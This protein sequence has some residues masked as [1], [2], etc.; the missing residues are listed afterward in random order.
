MPFRVGDCAGDVLIRFTTDLAINYQGGVEA[1][2][3]RRYTGGT[4]NRRPQVRQ[5]QLTGA[6]PRLRLRPVNLSRQGAS[7]D[8]GVRVIALLTAA[9]FINYIDRGNLATA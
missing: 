4:R 3:R 7:K 8:V 6:G 1:A 5:P 2:L 9:A